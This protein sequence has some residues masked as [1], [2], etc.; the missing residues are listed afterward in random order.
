MG[1]RELMRSREGRAG[2]EEEGGDGGNGASGD[3]HGCVHS[4]CSVEARE[5]EQEARVSAWEE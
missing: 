4:T 2:V 5:D 1:R 3:G